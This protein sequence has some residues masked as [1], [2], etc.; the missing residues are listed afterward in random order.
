VDRNAR[1][2]AISVN[3]VLTGRIPR[4]TTRTVGACFLIDHLSGLGGRLV[5]ND[6]AKIADGSQENNCRGM[7]T[8]RRR[9]PTV[10]TVGNYLYGPGAERRLWEVPGLL[11]YPQG[12]LRSI[13]EKSRSGSTAR[14]FFGP[15]SYARSSMI[16]NPARRSR[17]MSR[18]TDFVQQP[19]CRARHLTVCGSR[20][21]R[22]RRMQD[23]RFESCIGTGRGGPV[24]SHR[25]PPVSPWDLAAPRP[26]GGHLHFR[27]GHRGAGCSRCRPWCSTAIPPWSTRSRRR[28]C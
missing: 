8:E 19:A 5:G 15:H 4:A 12:R 6:Q 25:R 23:W 28:P 9:L 3:R 17:A 7:V 18:R 26:L 20:R 27:P 24:A 11:A 22:S 14:Y 16:R 21:S 2:A 13:A 1:K 10:P